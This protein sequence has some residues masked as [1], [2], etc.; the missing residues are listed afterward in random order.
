MNYP[1][2]NVRVDVVDALRGFAVVAIA[3]LHFIEHFIYGVYPESE[4]ET[5]NLINQGTWDALFFLFAGK[6]YAIF[7]LLFGFTFIIQQRNQEAKGADFGGR[8]AWRLILLMLFATLNA[9]FFPGGDVL[10]LFAIMGFVMIPLRKLSQKWLFIIALIFLVQPVELLECFGINLIP[11]VLNDAY[12]PALKGVVDTGNFWQMIWENITTGQLASLFW[13]VDAGRLLQAPGLFILGMILA[14]G[15]YFSRDISFWVK[16]FVV[17]VV[18]S[19]VL[20][21]AKISATDSL[22][23]IFTMWYNIAFTGILISIFV[24]LYQSNI[25]KKMTN[26]LRL[27]G[28]MSLTNYVSQSIIGSIIFFPYAFGLASVL[29]IALSLVV[30]IIVIIIQ[31]WGCKLWLNNH[32]QG[33]LEYIWH[34]ATWLK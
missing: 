30:G 1:Q 29:G 14:R 3:L 9:A 17:G 24:I 4:C 6:S 18:S 22:Q 33:P 7:A 8:F 23:I 5:I 11:T 21:I 10:L 13:A 28:R 26:G 15:D 31:I 27:Y 25:F 2:K 19:F 20:Y 16:L 32:K 34:R 12:Y